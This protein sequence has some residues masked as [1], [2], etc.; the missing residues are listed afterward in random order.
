MTKPARV[1][2]MGRTAGAKDKG[3]ENRSDKFHGDGKKEIADKAR[4][5]A[6]NYSSYTYKDIGKQDS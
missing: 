1:A 4:W 6:R 3:N 5:F 2:G